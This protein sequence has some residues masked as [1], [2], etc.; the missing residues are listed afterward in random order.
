MFV[1][2]SA[3]L[4]LD[5]KTERQ[6]AIRQDLIERDAPLQLEGMGDSQRRSHQLE[7]DW[8]IVRALLFCCPHSFLWF[9]PT[10]YREH[11][12]NVT[13]KDKV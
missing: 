7:F 10:K 1:C 3:K 8:A 12:Q 4:S 2:N 9:R 11:K 6:C 13:G 5:L